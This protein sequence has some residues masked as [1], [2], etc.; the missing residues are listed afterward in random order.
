MSIDLEST[1]LERIT[2]DEKPLISSE[3]NEIP[4][5]E[6]GE[7][8]NLPTDIVLRS[9]DGIRFGA[10]SKNLEIYSDGF[11]IADS[12]ARSTEDIILPEDSDVVLLL[13]RFM[14][15]Q[16]QPDLSLLASR[17]LIKFANAVEKYGV[18]SATG[19]Y[20]QPF[21]VFLY[22]QR[23]GYSSIMDKAG[24]LAITQEPANFFAY[25][26]SIG[27]TTWRDLAELE[28]HNLPTKEV[29]EALRQ[30]PDWPP[31]FGAWYLKREQMREAIFDAL[32]NPSPVLHKGGLMH[33]ADCQY[34]F[35]ADVLGKMGTSIPSYKTFVQVIE[36]C[37]PRLNGCTHCNIVVNNLIKSRMYTLDVIARK[38]LASY[39]DGD[40]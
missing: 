13:L 39:L 7:S 9:S 12:V 8:C 16:P 5:C 30:Y 24:K 27:D 37:L 2:P 19:V 20:D 28:T 10:H 6:A 23:H 26:H 40:R 18:Y 36:S 32:K 21:E 15:H 22:A 1:V 38:S 29:W 34:P 17:L 35:L 14:H 25:A 33:C 31:I 4:P 11:P 3:V